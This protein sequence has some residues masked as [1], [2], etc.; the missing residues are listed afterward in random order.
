MKFYREVGSSLFL[1]YWFDQV[2][3]AQIFYRA[4]GESRDR[5]E[6]VFSRVL[7]FLFVGVFAGFF[8]CR[9][10]DFVGLGLVGLRFFELFADY[11]VTCICKLSSRAFLRG[12]DGYGGCYGACVQSSRVEGVVRGY[13]GLLR[14]DLWLLNII[15]VVEF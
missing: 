13:S 9:F 4:F 11:V 15:E 14:L 2:F 6:R 10:W 3:T 5:G 12:V 1:L 7:V 8:I